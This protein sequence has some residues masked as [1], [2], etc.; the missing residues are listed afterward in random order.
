MMETSSWR[1][2]KSRSKD[3]IS[4]TRRRPFLSALGPN[5]Q[6]LA[7]LDPTSPFAYSAWSR[8][9]HDLAAAVSISPELD[10]PISI[11][12][13]LVIELVFSGQGQGKKLMKIERPVE[14]AN[15]SLYYR[16]YLWEIK[17]NYSAL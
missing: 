17:L 5:K 4:P 16:L 8:L 7:T 2:P 3:F 6:P 15:V 12:H 14:I 13:S 10:L 11:S 9:P 1:S